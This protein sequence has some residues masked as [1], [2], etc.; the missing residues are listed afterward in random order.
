MSAYIIPTTHNGAVNSTFN[1]T[2]YTPT[3]TAINSSQYVQLTGGTM[4]GA[5]STVGLTTTNGFTSSTTTGSNTFNNNITLPTNYSS[6]PS[7]TLLGGMITVNASSSSGVNNAITNI[8]TITLSV[9]VWAIN[10][11]VALICGVSSST[12][13]SFIIALSTANN[14]L[15]TNTRISYNVNSPYLAYGGTNNESAFVG[16]YIT[17]VSSSTTTLYLNYFAYITG[18]LTSTGYISAVR[19]A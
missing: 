13:S 9:G 19:I 6:L 15:N 7:V 16:S 4:T 1:T 10:Y 11:R 17:S 8:A 5:L 2:D 18:T 12:T 14:H 3:Q